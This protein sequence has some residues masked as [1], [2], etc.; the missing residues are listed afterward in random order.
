MGEGRAEPGRAQ[1][2]HFWEM[3]HVSRGEAGRA[4]GLYGSGLAGGRGS[5]MARD[6][7]DWSG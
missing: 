7:L 6:S 5:R 3:A 1:R 2:R 4:R